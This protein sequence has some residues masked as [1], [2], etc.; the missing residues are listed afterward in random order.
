[1]ISPENQSRGSVSQ[2]KSHTFSRRVSD[3]PNSRSLDDQTGSFFRTKKVFFFPKKVVFGDS[4]QK[5]FRK[6][7]ND[8]RNTR[9][10]DDLQEKDKQ[11]K[12]GSW[13]VE[14]FHVRS[15]FSLYERQNSRSS[16]KYEWR[17]FTGREFRSDNLRK[18]TGLAQRCGLAAHH[19]L[20]RF[21]DA[22]W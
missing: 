9:F 15:D 1:M 16:L 21:L 18:L 10:S 3:S 19:S 4:I 12:V 7:S 14:F 6:A 5:F 13:S 17:I 8:L 2:F 11:A 22:F 20:V